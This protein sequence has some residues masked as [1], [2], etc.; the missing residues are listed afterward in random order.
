MV[1][2]WATLRLHYYNLLG[3]KWSLFHC[4]SKK[5]IT[6]I[7]SSETRHNKSN[8]MAELLVCEDAQNWTQ[9]QER[10]FVRRPNFLP[11]TIFATFQFF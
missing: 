5:R 10:V 3:L 4:R 9:R 7:L 11:S 8:Q 1:V 6:Y 2:S